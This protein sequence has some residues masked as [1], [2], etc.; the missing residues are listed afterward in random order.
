MKFFAIQHSQQPELFLCFNSEFGY[1]SWQPMFD[2]T[3]CRIGETFENVED[4][5]RHLEMVRGLKLRDSQFAKIVSID[6]AI[7]VQV[8]EL[9]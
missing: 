1:G 2:F 8:S 6:V 9:E 3:S 7:N 5:K 4:A